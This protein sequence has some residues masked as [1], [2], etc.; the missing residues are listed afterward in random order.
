MPTIY[1]NCVTY[2]DGSWDQTLM[3]ASSY[4]HSSHFFNNE[5]GVYRDGSMHA[6]VVENACGDSYGLVTSFAYL[7]MLM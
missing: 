1:A 7:G 4:K 6:Q 5:V 2:E 3:V